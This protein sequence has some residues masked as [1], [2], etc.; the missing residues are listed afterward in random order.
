MRAPQ[1]PN[2]FVVGRGGLGRSP[3]SR[4]ECINSESPVRAE[5]TGLRA[6][7]Y[8][9]EP[10]ELVKSHRFARALIGGSR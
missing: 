6:A 1:F 10:K 3:K 9:F 4:G 7:R 5:A 8:A 2:W